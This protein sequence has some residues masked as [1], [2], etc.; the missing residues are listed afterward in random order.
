MN[1]RNEKNCNK[2]QTAFLRVF[3]LGKTKGNGEY[4]SLVIK[5]YLLFDEEQ[6]FLK[7]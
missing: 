5:I 2:H 7:I 6:Q 1:P 3:A 4:S